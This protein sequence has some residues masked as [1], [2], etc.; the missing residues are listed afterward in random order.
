MLLIKLLK[1]INK[2]YNHEVNGMTILYFTA[3]G[4]SLQVAKWIGGTPLSIPQ[5]VRKTTYDFADDDIGVIFPIYGFGLPK[6]VKNFLEKI[7][8]VAKYTFAVG[9][10][11]NVPGAVMFNLAKLAAKRGLKF[12]YMTSLLMADNYLPGFDMGKETLRLSE[13]KTFE[14]LNKIVSDI[15]VHKTNIPAASISQRAMTAVIQGMQGYFINGKT[16]Q[17]YIVDNQCTHCGICAKVCP[18]GNITVTDKV[19]FS[20]RCEVCL[21]CVHNCPSNAIHLKNEKSAARFRNAD[22]TLKEIQEANCQI[23]Y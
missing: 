8:I 16:A 4:N 1:R 13:K 18:T 21:G 7:G 14:N 12:D 15:H 10:Y 9:T 6:I 17:G 20:N 23:V 22:V 19:I 3:T 11:G 5:M 2:V